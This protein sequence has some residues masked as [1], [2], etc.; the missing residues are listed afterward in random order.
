MSHYSASSSQWFP[1][2]WGWALAAGD[3][4]AVPM[5]PGPAWVCVMEVDGSSHCA[6]FTGGSPLKDG[7]FEK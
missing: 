1:S 2:T 6:L 4:G 3:R 7:L 5:A